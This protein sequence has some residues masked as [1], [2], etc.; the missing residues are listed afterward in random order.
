VIDPE[1]V[2]LDGWIGALSL[3]TS[4]QK[5]ALAAAA[6]RAGRLERPYS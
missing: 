3:H 5:I 6:I 4:R 2:N 1:R